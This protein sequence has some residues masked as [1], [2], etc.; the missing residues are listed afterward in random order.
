[1]EVL[2]MKRYFNQET[3]DTA[4]SYMS[5]IKRTADD[6][7]IAFAY[8][9]ETM[10]H[11][12][13]RALYNDVTV[14]KEAE[15]SINRLFDEAI[16]RILNSTLITEEDFMLTQRFADKLKKI[17]EDSIITDETARRNEIPKSSA[18][19]RAEALLKQLEA[20]A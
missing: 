11:Y 2:I 18:S 10:F 1:M 6:Y 14:E 20:L 8:D 13:D 5:C 16:P 17:F 3:A 19:I 9:Y 12:I 15:S 7:D 4:K